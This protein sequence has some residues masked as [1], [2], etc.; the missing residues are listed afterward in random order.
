MGG[1][2]VD[3]QKWKIDRQRVM[4][5]MARHGHKLERIARQYVCRYYGIRRVSEPLAEIGERDGK[6]R[7]AVQ[8]VV[9]RA[10][11]RLDEWER[12]D[13]RIAEYRTFESTG[14]NGGRGE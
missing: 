8:K 5:L 3:S 4:P 11:A 7:T 13:A 6:T 10:V 14:S 1:P 2:G 9:I 12:E